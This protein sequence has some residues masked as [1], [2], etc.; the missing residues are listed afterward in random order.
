MRSIR[1]TIVAA[2]LLTTAKLCL[3]L[4]SLRFARRVLHISSRLLPARADADAI[5]SSIAR[6]V[7][8][9]PFKFTCLHE[10]LAAEA[11]MR[12]NSV[13]CNLRIG[14]RKDQNRHCFHAWLE[15]GGVTVIGATN[16][17]H[18]ILLEP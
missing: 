18:T 7:R 3:R 11:L 15:S 5:S 8:H 1:L 17:Q 2:I 13:P 14:A 4:G 9:L 6:A 16:V 10:A 12:T